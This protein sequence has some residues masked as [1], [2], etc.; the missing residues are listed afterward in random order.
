[1]HSTRCIL[2][3]GS[4][5]IAWCSTCVRQFISDE[6]NIEQPPSYLLQSGCFRL[7]GTT[8]L[9]LS[10]DSDQDLHRHDTI[11]LDARNAEREAEVAEKKW[12]AA[13]QRVKTLES[14]VSNPVQWFASMMPFVKKELTNL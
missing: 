14:T 5:N 7:Q 3:V 6:H 4:D 2:F 10:A 1:M 11:S 12:L 9:L 13:E 8:V